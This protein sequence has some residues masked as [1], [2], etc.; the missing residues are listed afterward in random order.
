MNI[1]TMTKSDAVEACCMSVVRGLTA[2]K[3]PARIG[4][5]VAACPPA[6]SQIRTGFYEIRPM[7]QDRALRSLYLMRRKGVVEQ[8]RVGLNLLWRLVP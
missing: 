8:E 3:R 4:E 7:N 2:L 6:P 5:I 1:V